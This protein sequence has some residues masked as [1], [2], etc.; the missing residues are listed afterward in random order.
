MTEQIEQLLLSEDDSNI[1]LG[2][3]L[4]F[5]QGIGDLYELCKWINNKEPLVSSIYLPMAAFFQLTPNLSVVHLVIYIKETF[6]IPI[7]NLL[8]FVKDHFYKCRNV[9]QYMVNYEIKLKKEL[10]I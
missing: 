9:N 4:Y 8:K 10:G 2:L 7:Q 5:S 1:R 6:K 3:T